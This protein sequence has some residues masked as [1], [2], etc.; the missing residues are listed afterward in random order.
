MRY[1]LTIEGDDDKGG[2]G[3]GG[4]D[5][6]GAGGLLSDHKVEGDD[7]DDDG[8][9][10]GDDA[11]GAGD[12][13]GKGAGD[14]EDAAKA[15]A[16]AAAVSPLH[17]EARPEHVPENFW[18]KD[19]EGDGG[20]IELE[21]LTKS[22]KDLRSRQATKG[23]APAK[24]EDYTFE[25]TSPVEG[26]DIKGDDMLVTAFRQVAF[27]EGMPQEQFNRIAGKYSAALI[28]FMKG[29]IDAGEMEQYD[30]DVE[31]KKLGENGK[32]LMDGVKGWLK[33]LVTRGLLS[34]GQFTRLVT[35]G[36]YADGISGLAVLRSLAGEVPIPL[37]QPLEGEGMPS[38]EDLYARV[39]D[40]RY[41][42]GTAFYKETEALF[43]KRWGR[44]AA[45]A[46]PAGL[47]VSTRP[48]PAA[49]GK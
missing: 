36:D 11:G 15:K 40:E 14:D 33:G 13:G 45:G 20:T 49:K 43:Q 47:G 10:K 26:M 42:E 34:E 48:Q 3:G 28:N 2:G 18:K 24:P 1:Q 17:F 38:D 44:S 31:L 21:A 4:D 22:H 19:E 27:D 5:D 25:F 29:K 37:G 41:R 46:S 7:G 35:S 8:K 6:K 16:A 12:D 39:G 23:K 32:P 9:K 30:Q